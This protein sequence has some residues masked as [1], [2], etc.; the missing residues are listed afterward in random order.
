[1]ERWAASGRTD[2]LGEGEGP[3]CTQWTREYHVAFLDEW[4][5][6]AGNITGKGSRDQAVERPG[7]AMT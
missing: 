3:K 4:Q 7:A 1:M 6:V 2:N 5:E